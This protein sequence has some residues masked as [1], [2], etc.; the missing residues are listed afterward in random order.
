VVIQPKSYQ[1]YPTI[2]GEYDKYS[3]FSPDHILLMVKYDL[4]EWWKSGQ[5]PINTIQAVL[6]N[7]Q[8]AQSGK[9]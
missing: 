4:E 7:Q 9:G 2:R 8:P 6:I 5:N 3:I 1:H